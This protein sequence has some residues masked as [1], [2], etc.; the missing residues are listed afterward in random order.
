VAER[1]RAGKKRNNNLS[2]KADRHK[3]V[4]LQK[5]DVILPPQLHH[6]ARPA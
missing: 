4:H 2:T 1:R 5:N 3:T 6:H